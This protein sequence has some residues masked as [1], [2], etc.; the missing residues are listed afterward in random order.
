MLLIKT[1]TWGLTFDRK[2]WVKYK[3]NTKRRI[4]K[5][6]QKKTDY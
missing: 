4:Y 5:W 6:E 3:Y 2:L 1:S